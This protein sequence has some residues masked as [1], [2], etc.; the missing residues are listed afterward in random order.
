MVSLVSNFT[1]STFHAID[2]TN[3]EKVMGAPEGFL[4]SQDEGN[5]LGTCETI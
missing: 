5:K 2:A 3:A 1:S 4:E